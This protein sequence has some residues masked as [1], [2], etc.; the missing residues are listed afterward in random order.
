MK[1]ENHY[2]RIQGKYEDWVTLT[3]R[4]TLNEKRK[5]KVS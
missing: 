2:G 5:V 3:S 1:Q 4:V